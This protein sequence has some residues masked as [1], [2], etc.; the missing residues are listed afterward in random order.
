MFNQQKP[1]VSFVIPCYNC[2]DKMDKL[3]SS[4][5]NQTDK[6]FEAIFVDD[7]SS[8]GTFAKLTEYAEKSTF[9]MRVVKNE[10]NSGP[11]ITRN[12]GIRLVEGEYVTFVDSDDYISEGSVGIWREILSADKDIDCLAFDYNIVK[13]EEVD[14][15]RIY[16]GSLDTD[17]RTVDLDLKKS[18]VYISGS[19]WCKVYKTSIITDNDVKFLN[20]MRNEDMPFTK[21]AL[22]YS[23]KTVYLREPLYY[24]VMYPTSLVHTDSL[25]N[26]RNT[27]IGFEAVEN[28]LR[29]TH[30]AECEAIFALELY[31]MVQNMI[32]EKAKR[33]DLINCI[34]DGE[35]RFS[36]I[37]KNKYLSEYPK[38]YRIA[39]FL[40]RYKL[41][42]GLR[43]VY[44]IAK[45]RRRI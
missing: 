2:I 16:I 31:T 19:T 10:V 9:N 44:K 33:K 4:L 6:D 3:L 39:F 21:R 30:Y 28:S 27:V 22:K 1:F 12:N 18:I 43:A 15:R 35:K 29:D 7:C 25:R 42:L 45:L 13:G 34:R 41:V 40:I 36:T 14:P 20:L 37:W 5:E 11:G 17:R 38:K 23:R 32:S 24:Y 26:S 8:D